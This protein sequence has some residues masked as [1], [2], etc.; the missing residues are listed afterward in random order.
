MKQLPKIKETTFDNQT[1]RISTNIPK[2]SFSFF[3]NFESLCYKNDPE[4][5]IRFVKHNWWRH[6]YYVICNTEVRV[7]SS[8]LKTESDVIRVISAEQDLKERFSES[9]QIPLNDV[10][11]AVQAVTS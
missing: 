7:E 4:D 8:A 10:T 11:E 1:M 2:N 5:K 6:L 9:C 3:L